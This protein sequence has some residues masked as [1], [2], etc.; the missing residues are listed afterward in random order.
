LALAEH[1]VAPGTG[2]FPNEAKCEPGKG[3]NDVAL[4]NPAFTEHVGGV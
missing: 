1:I 2:L 3:L 4:M